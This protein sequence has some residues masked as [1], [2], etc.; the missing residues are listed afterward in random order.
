MGKDTWPIKTMISVALDGVSS[1]KNVIQV[2][3]AQV[4]RLKSFSKKH[5]KRIVAPVCTLNLCVDCVDIF[6][7]V[8]SVVTM[9]V[10]LL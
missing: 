1:P 8:V 4:W 2:V 10:P 5:T 9:I 6:I 3:S 7:A